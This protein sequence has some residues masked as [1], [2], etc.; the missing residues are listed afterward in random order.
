MLIRDPRSD[1][2]ASAKNAQSGTSSQG[3][4]LEMLGVDLGNGCAAVATIAV[5]RT[6][7]T[8]GESAT[9]VQLLAADV[10][11]VAATIVNTDTTKTMYVGL[12]GAP[13]V[14][15]TNPIPPLGSYNVPPANVQAQ[16]N[17]IWDAGATGGANVLATTA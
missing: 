12:N 14:A 17:G 2:S 11:R 8:V 3:G 10:T 9:S 13:A 1:G 16:I 15:G 4:F 7:T 5:T 6:K